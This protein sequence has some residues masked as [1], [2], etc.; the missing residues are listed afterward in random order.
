MVSNSETLQ[1]STIHNIELS[2]QLQNASQLWN[3]PGKEEMSVYD[4]DNISFSGSSTSEIADL[5]NNKDKIVVIGQDEK[6]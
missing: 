2:S 6:V 3:L 4:L 1:K 5:N